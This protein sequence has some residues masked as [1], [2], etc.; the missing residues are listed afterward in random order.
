MHPFVETVSV[1]GG[2]AVAIVGVV[3]VLNLFYRGVAWLSGEGK[4]DPMAVHGV[5][6][7]NTLATV[8]VAGSKPFERVRFVGFTNSQSLKTHWPFELDGMVI[9]EDESKTRFLIR[10][11]DIRMVIVPAD[12]ESGDS[13][14]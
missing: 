3:I 1:A 14:T 10:S 4:P 5:L 13:T 8:H 2:I 9:L 12:D 6:K 7:K 11:K